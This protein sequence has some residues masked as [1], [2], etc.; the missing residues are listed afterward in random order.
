MRHPLRLL[1]MALLHLLSLLLVA[2]L[3]LLLL[4]LVVVLLLRLL[5]FLFLPLLQLLV[6]LVLP[7]GQLLLLLLVFPVQSR[8]ARAGN[9]LRL[10]LRQFAGMRRIR[11]MRPFSTGL[12]FVRCW[13]SMIFA[14]CI[15]GFNHAMP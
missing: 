11:R 4:L 8:I 15:A 9:M 6:F 2:L 14:A 1:L 12:T 10:V 5:V 13:R 7:V 3:H